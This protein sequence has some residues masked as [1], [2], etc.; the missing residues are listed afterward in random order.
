M[1]SGLTRGDHRGP[2]GEGHV[3]A[4]GSD[5]GS[6]QAGVAIRASSR[7][8][9]VTGV[10]Q[11]LAGA[12]NVLVTVLAARA[13][14]VAGFGY[15]GIVFMIYVM[16]QGVSRALVGDPL[17][18][19]PAESHTRRGDVLGVGMVL[20]AGLA[21]VV[22]VAGV[23]TTAWSAQLG[24]ALMVLAACLPFL[25]LQDLGRYV[26]FA[27]QRPALALTLDTAWL[28]LVIAGAAFVLAGDHRT[29][30]WF[31]TAWAGSGAV[32][33]L[34][35]FG[36]HGVARPRVRW[37]VETWSY[38]WKFLVSYTSTQGS[39]LAAS[40]GVGAIAGP[41]ALGGV[42]GA[43]L[44]VRPFMTLQVAV[45]ATGVPEIARLDTSDQRV[46]GRVRT[47]T[48]VA[49]VGAAVNGV[50]LLVLPDVL[51]R[52]VLG[53][54]WSAAQPL[55]LPAAAQILLI[56][57]V[58]GPRSGLIGLRALGRTV[59][60][61]VAS[62]VAVLAATVVGALADGA[63]GAM[64]GRVICWV[65]VALVWWATWLQHVRTRGVAAP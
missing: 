29:L 59:P 28:V 4:G 14:S 49:G 11:A 31:V 5:T 21:A 23:V 17:L 10:D 26:G 65:V 24:E 22:L 51:G 3:D 19:H 60:I 43:F 61:D 32:S 35:V 37:L 12:S 2:E 36:Q 44:L 20:G 52:A 8:L 50:L 40:A 47:M 25:V 15:F 38:S 64:W 58:T 46:R 13:L 42:Q 53:A 56:A 55:L 16:A 33:G 27:Q 57:L 39:A 1:V 18:L 48:L 30:V 62:T 6:D 54:T 9:S 41:R 63:A 45:A 34:L 7:R